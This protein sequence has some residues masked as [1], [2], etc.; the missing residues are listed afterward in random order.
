MR[1]LYDVDT[2][3]AYMEAL[4]E[5]W[6]KQTLLNVRDMILKAEPGL[7]E[8]VNYK[9]LAYGSETRELFHLNAQS[10]YVSLYVGNIETVDPGRTLLSAFSLGKGCI[11]FRK[12]ANLSDPGLAKFIEQAVALWRKGD[13]IDC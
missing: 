9:M 12:S 10:A 7:V 11:R 5:D 4:D 13:A 6:R 2:P 3:H 1:M 8:R